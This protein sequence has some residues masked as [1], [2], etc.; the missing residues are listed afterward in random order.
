[1]NFMKSIDKVQ[2]EELERMKKQLS[3]IGS[4]EGNFISVEILFYEAITFS[5]TLGDAED[6]QLLAALKQIQATEYRAA[7]EH[8]SKS[9]MREKAIRRFISRFK[10]ALAET[11]NLH[12]KQGKLEAQ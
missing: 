12:K 11:I 10:I 9:T 1:M 7:K 2:K 8:Y 3:L 4:K 5:R 6:N